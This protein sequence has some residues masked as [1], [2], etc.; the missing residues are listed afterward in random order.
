[1]EIEE[2]RE[3]FLTLS[4]E[5]ICAIHEALLESMYPITREGAALKRDL[6][7]KLERLLI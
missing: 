7:N 4:Y 1:M 6:H 3:F 2:R 5:E